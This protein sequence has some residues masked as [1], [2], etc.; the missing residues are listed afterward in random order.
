MYQLSTV[1]GEREIYQVCSYVLC[2]ITIGGRLLRDELTACTSI[3]CGP[4]NS[5][6]GAET[7]APEILR[8]LFSHAEDQT[9]TSAWSPRGNYSH[10]GYRLGWL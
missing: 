2:T 4:R 7:E 10:F 3:K 5:F 6:Q 8:G 9:D 1:N